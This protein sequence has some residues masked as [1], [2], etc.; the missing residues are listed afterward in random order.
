MANNAEENGVRDTAE[1]KTNEE[2]QAVSNR[3][4]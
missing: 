2:N 1:K 3:L 4:N